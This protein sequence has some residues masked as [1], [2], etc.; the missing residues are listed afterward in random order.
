MKRPASLPLAQT[1]L[2]LL[3]TCNGL[4]GAGILALLIAMLAAG[5]WTFTALGVPPSPETLSLRQGMAWVAVLGGLATLLNHAVLARLKAIVDTV[6]VGDAFVA[7]NARRLR[8]IAWVLLGLQLLGLAI[9]AVGEAVS[10]PAHPLHLDAGIS[11]SGWLAVVLSFVL[12]R[13]FAEGT[14]MRQDLEGTV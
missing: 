12:A 8:D 10:S 9:G 4:F 5:P 13:V 11:V 6:Q 7:A 2:R 14:A 1:V 3:L